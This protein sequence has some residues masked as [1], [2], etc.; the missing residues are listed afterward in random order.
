M[1][2]D[3]THVFRVHGSYTLP[4]SLNLGADVSVES[5]TPMGKLGA[6]IFYPPGTRYVGPRGAPGRTDTIFNVDLPADYTLKL[7]Q[8]T[9]LTLTVD[10]FNLL[11]QQAATD[12]DTVVEFTY[13]QYRAGMTDAEIRQ[14]NPD[15]LKTRFFSPPL[16]VRF[17]ARLSF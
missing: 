10:V 15:Y 2:A 16:A 9:H 8:R 11:N 13:G 5:G 3:R 4:M 1:F 14:I 7:T 17:G 12:K 6:L